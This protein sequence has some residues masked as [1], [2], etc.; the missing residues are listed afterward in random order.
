MRFLLAILVF[1]FSRHVTHAQVSID[2]RYQ[3]FQNTHVNRSIEAFNLAHAYTGKGLHYLHHGYAASLGKMIKISQPRS[4]FF[5]IDLPYQRLDQR[6][7]TQDLSQWITHEQLGLTGEFIF[8][9][10]ALKGKMST[11]PLGTRLYYIMG[12]GYA[13]T[14]S[15]VRKDG[16]LLYRS[17][18]QGSPTFVMGMGQRRSMI[19]SRIVVSPF[20]KLYASPWRNIGDYQKAILGTALNPPTGSH[21]VWQANAGIEFTWLK[22]ERKR[23]GYLKQLFHKKVKSATE[24]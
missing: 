8:H 22:K 24:I 6:F 18:P 17:L 2:I 3:F 11:G 1:L 13:Y 4:I 20:F 15:S 9:P 12:A 23:S 14:R 10:K 5:K 7:V 16:E 21:I 19:R